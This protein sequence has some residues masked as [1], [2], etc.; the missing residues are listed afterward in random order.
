MF[1]PHKDE[2]Y[3]KLWKTVPRRTAQVDGTLEINILL[4][5]YSIL[6]Q[7]LGVDLRKSNVVYWA[8][9]TAWADTRA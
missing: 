8:L 2:T 7:F 3:N 6:L 5:V 4:V 1:Q 9:G